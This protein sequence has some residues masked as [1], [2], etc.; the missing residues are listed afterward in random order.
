MEDPT[1]FPGA[2]EADNLTFRDFCVEKTGSEDV[3]HITDAI[4]TALLGLNSNEL[5]AF[6]M[7]YYFKSGSGIDNLLSDERDG[8]QY[9]RTRQ[10]KATI[11]KPL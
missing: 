2:T 4:S 10:G 3:I 8:A 11:V 6:Y 7:L 5:S 1:S 9:L